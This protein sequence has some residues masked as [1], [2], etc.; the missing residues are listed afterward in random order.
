M[1]FCFHDRVDVA[2]DDPEKLGEGAE[3]GV[4]RTIDIDKDGGDGRKGT[5]YCLTYFIIKVAFLSDGDTFMDVENG[6]SS[7]SIRAIATEW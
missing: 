5:E 4:W 2:L 7:F 1:I 6:S 3:R